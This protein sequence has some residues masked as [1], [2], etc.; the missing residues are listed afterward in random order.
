VDQGVA[1]PKSPATDSSEEVL[2]V[3]RRIR[4]PTDS[5]T[6]F[7]PPVMNGA[8]LCSSICVMPGLMDVS[9]IRACEDSAAT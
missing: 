2:D 9:L 5:I 6:E 3:H 7:S 8:Q 1:V 4:R